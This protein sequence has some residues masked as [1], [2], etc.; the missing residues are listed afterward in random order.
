M[1]N[2]WKERA[3]IAKSPG[4]PTWILEISA[5]AEIP[6]N[7]QISTF[8]DFPEIRDGPKFPRIRESLQ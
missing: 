7:P 2:F 4:V 5:K 8:S 6:K 1:G 3:E